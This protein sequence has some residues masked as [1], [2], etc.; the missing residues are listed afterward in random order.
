MA[1]TKAQGAV[2]GNRD[3]ISKRLG[4]KLFGGQKAKTG[5]IIARQK[6]TKVH[7]GDG[8]GMGS[9][10]TIFSLIDGIVKFRNSRGKKIVEVV[11]S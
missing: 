11:S 8:V 1:H 3:S 2:K 4:I 5:S 10:F 6:G 9:D 7:P